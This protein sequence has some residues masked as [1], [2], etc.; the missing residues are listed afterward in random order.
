M[1]PSIS[2]FAKKVSLFA[3]KSK[4]NNKDLMIEIK[5]KLPFQQINQNDQRENKY[6]I[7]PTKKN[8][9]IKIKKMLD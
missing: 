6:I 4:H 5:I 2:L 3:K 7:S 1:L 9:S 8:V